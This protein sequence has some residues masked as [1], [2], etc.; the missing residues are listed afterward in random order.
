MSVSGA[1]ATAAILGTKGTPPQTLDVRNLC[2]ADEVASV[3][4]RKD[5]QFPI[6]AISERAIPAMFLL[7][8]A[9][10]Q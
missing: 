5:E 7:Q 2:K 10:R 4:W 6:S 8:L 1:L 9:V 3:W